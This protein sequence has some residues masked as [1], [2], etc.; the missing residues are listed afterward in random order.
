MNY[1]IGFWLINMAV[2]SFVTMVIGYD[3]SAKERISIIGG[4]GL[5]LATLMLSIYLISS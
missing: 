3:L 2:A 5:F 4:T 1:Y